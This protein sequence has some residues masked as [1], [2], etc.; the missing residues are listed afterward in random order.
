[1]ADRISSLDN[2]YQTGDLSLFPEALD[3][4]ESLYEVTNNAQT[5]L[6]QTLSYNGSV[7]IVEDA[8]GFPPK[9]ILSIGPPPGEPGSAELVF[10][11]K[12]TS[13]TFQDL[14]RGFSGS[15]RN[16]WPA[17]TTFVTNGVNADYH[18]SVKDAL[19]NMEVNL[20]LEEFPNDDSLNGILKFQEVRFLAPKPLF[21]A[22]KIKGPP[23]LKVTFQN[24]TSGHIARYLWDFGDGATSLEKSPQHTYLTEGIYTVK[25]N[26]ITSTGAQGIATKT[27]YI[28]VDNNEAA[29]FFYVEDESNPY[30]VQTASELSE[31][32]KEFVFVDQTNGEIVQRNWI[33]GDGENTTEENPDSHEISHIYSEPG[34]YE[35]TLLAIFSNGRLKK[36]QL[37]DPLVVL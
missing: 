9:G 8:S 7:I 10:Y 1:M 31:S 26:V 30:S 16:F 36:Y 14:K 22:S 13:N 27:D 18:N 28:T 12:K 37:K 11:N 15:R 33:F 17:R 32:P 4:K 29:P 21:R 23:A 5:T 25:L 3:D 2:G 35:V 24:F 34:E 19:I 20:G 6:K